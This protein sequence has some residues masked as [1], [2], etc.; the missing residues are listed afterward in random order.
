MIAPRPGRVDEGQLG[1]VHHDGARAWRPGL[2]TRATPD[3]VD[4]QDVDLAVQGR[5]LPVG[6]ALD[7]GHRFLGH[8]AFPLSKLPL[9][10]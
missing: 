5:P 10:R 9:W 7:T 3:L 1:Q 2:S 6:V 8:G 4:V